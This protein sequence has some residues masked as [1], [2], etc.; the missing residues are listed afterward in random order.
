MKSLRVVFVITGLGTGGAEISLLR[1]LSAMNRDR[2]DPYV[3][4]LTNVGI[5]SERITQL[6]IP[7]RFLGMDVHRPN[8]FLFFRLVVWL[9]EIRPDVIQT[10][11]YHA[12]LLGGL[13]GFSAGI[14]VVWGMHN[15]TI[16][17]KTTKK[18]TILVIRTCALFSHFV[19]RRIISCSARARD[20]HIGLGYK[21]MKFTIIPNGFDLGQFR[22]DETARSALRRQWGVENSSVLIGMAARFDPQK[23]PHNFIRAAQLLHEKYAQVR[24][25]LCGT[26]MEWPNTVLA[27]WI[28][29]ADLRSVFYPL[30]CRDDMPAVLSALDIHTLSSAYGEAFPNVLGEAMACGVPCVTTD[31]GDAAEIVGDTG[32]AVPPRDV[33]ALAQGWERMI[34]LS[35][36]ERCELGQRARARIQ[37]HYQIDKV[38]Q[39]YQQ[40]YQQL[41]QG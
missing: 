14:P 18:S 11:M 9:R 23:D 8:I 34:N 29:A 4:S 30:G 35:M 5:I 25:L 31:V 40:L 13:A 15:S 36:Q 1:L 41:I 12:D 20:I 16:D 39:R 21:S 37:S 28:D 7:V 17:T 19:P 2:F 26:G 10:W 24:F 32:I 33:H 6:G 38:V 22:P 3:I 27:G